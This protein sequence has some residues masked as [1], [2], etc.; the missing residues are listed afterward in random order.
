MADELDTLALQV[1]EDHKLAKTRK[2]KEK[3]VEVAAETDD[4]TPANDL[5]GQHNATIDRLYRM[6]EEAEF[7]GRTLLGDL[8]DN[9]LDF[10]KSRP[11]VWSQMSNAEQRDLAKAIE[12]M[13]KEFTRK[14]V[15]LI[16]AEDTPTILAQLKTY[17]CADGFKIQLTAPD[18]AE[19]AKQLYDM[20][21]LQVILMRADA[22][23]FQNVRKDA[24]TDPDQN[25]FS[26]EAAPN[27]N[28]F[29]PNPNLDHPGD[30]GDLAGDE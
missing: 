25:D 23:R 16:A 8:R 22:Q 9:V 14:A 26:F 18:D 2:P 1:A 10:I 29:D 28:G 24:D 6:V 4:D 3:P 20:H 15:L 13:A 30:D 21:G 27:P 7:E 5:E 19:T 12:F 11:R 17:S